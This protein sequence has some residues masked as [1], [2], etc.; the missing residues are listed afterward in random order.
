MPRRPH[1]LYRPAPFGLPLLAALV[2]LT[3]Q[4][5]TAPV[6][7]P[8]PA[9]AEAPPLRVIRGSA[10]GRLQPRQAIVLRADQATA[11]LGAELDAQGNVELRQ[12]DTLLRAPTLSFNE[13][14]NEV[15]APGN[16]RIE[17]LGSIIDGQ[18]LRLEL[19]TFLGELLAPRY[20]LATTGGSGTAE[21]MDFE[22]EQRLRT[23]AGSY[24]SC[25]RE[26]DAPPAWELRTD[27]LTLD[28]AQSKGS[29]DGVV[30]RFLD[31]PILAA[32]SFT[33]P[34]GDTRM[35]GWLPPHIGADNRSGFELAVPYYFNLADNYDATVTPFGMTRR[36][37][38]VDGEVR[39]LTPFGSAAWEASWLPHDRVA[40]RTRWS[41]HL[42]GE[43]RPWEGLRLKADVE[44]VSD[45]DY[46]KDL[47][48]RI[49]SPTPRLLARDLQLTQDGS[50]SPG[51]RWQG[52]ARIQGWQALQTHEAS[53][54]ITT[55]YQREP[56]IGLRLNTDTDIG[57]LAGFMPRMHRPRLEGGL[58][59]EYNRFTLPG[60]A[61]PT[62]A[63][64]GQRMH[65]LGH[66]ALPVL[67]P[68]WWVI[69]Q[70]QVNAANYRV[71]T[72][73]TDVRRSASRVVPTFSVDAGMAF[74]RDTRLLGRDLLQSLEPR[75]LF[76]NT[77]YRRQ[78]NLPNFDSAP[79][80]FNAE[81]L[82]ATNPFTG[83]DRVAD[84][85]T[86]SFGAVSRWLSPSSGE[87]QLR[88]GLVQR[89]QF[90]D[91][92]ITADAGTVN[93]RFS[94]V[95]F[96]GG[97]HLS[98]PWWLD[99][100]VQYDPELGRSV[101]SV[102][103]ARYSPGAFKTVSLAYRL[104]RSQSE[105]LDVAWQWPLFGKALRNNSSCKGAW[106]TAG[107]IQYSLRESRITDSLLG[108][109]YDAGCYV[110]RI[111][112]ERLSTGL[113]QTNTRFLL[114]LELV[115]LSRLGSSALKVLR[116]NVPGY[117]PLASDDA[118]PVTP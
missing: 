26:G 22:G 111:G 24:S 28:L 108:L 100:A 17:H 42:V 60:S 68:A 8:P 53:S 30:L 9:V 5:Q 89:Y 41:S 14:R 34:L 67:D 107:R 4:A 21:R 79:R 18:A 78:D 25:P 19:D 113:S 92:R 40:G 101:R 73:L 104:Q 23:T 86:L 96:T 105:Q 88:L 58:E 13:A 44:A 11:K 12:G 27:R 51:A 85:R 32:P 115:G 55:P 62:Q 81:A 48:R 56:Q 91:Q 71:S 90:R 46:W 50:L 82:Y 109:E 47:R 69:P 33:F 75:L 35:S 72:P 57:L 84:A 102:L 93:R 49:E 54:R 38:G 52:Y 1:L 99:G 36:G 77:P 95:V 61:L 116:D 117:R 66:L 2:T 15:R 63:P 10:P 43:A 97:A 76:V 106:Y 20:R 114:Q 6:P 87:E 112:V 74:E 59:L 3:A 110:V 80:D 16:V 65:A 94:D 39:G 103:R 31:V 64:G 70:L 37:A 7:V 83:I 29:A 118:L 45:D 98:E